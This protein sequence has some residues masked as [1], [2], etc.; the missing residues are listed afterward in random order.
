MQANFIETFTDTPS[1]D[2]WDT[3]T[4]NRKQRRETKELNRLLED[5]QAGQVS[6]TSRHSNVE[7][8]PVNNSR[9]LT[10]TPEGFF[11]CE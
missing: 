3:K 5:V 7:I 8:K 11:S 1:K 10:E 9:L 6:I 4:P 2:G